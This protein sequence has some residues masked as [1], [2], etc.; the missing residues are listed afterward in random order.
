MLRSFVVL[1]LTALVLR[2]AD[3]PPNVK[4]VEEIAA[5]VNG[6]IITRSE[7]QKKRVDIE[8]EARRQG[9]SGQRLKATV[10]EVAANALRDQIDQLL[11][12]QQAKNLN[13]NVDSDVTRRL[14][15][16]QLQ[17]KASHPE[18]SDP[19][20]FQSYIA[21]QTGMPFE[22]FKLQ[23]KNQLLTQRVIG[24]EV[25]RNIPIAEADMQKYYDEHKSEFVRKEGQVFLSQIVMS[26][27]GKTPDQVA[28]AEKKAK[29]VTARA[30][31]GEKF[32]EPPP[33]APVGDGGRSGHRTAPMGVLATT[34][35]TRMMPTIVHM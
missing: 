29:D 19:D 14:A 25:M 35:I 9:L 18:L 10:D 23:M 5:K 11:L 13:I 32:A 6:D 20:K 28:A 33:L 26:L 1:S 21:E 2:A 30:R 12:V 3:N 31:R 4:I 7:L 8:A 16:I 27:D 24:Q 22:D 17:Q 34:V 15:E